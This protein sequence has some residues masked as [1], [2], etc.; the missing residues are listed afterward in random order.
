[1]N[2]INVLTEMDEVK[3]VLSYSKNIGFFFGAG[4][5]C[6]I[7]LPD[8]L[9]LT[10]EV[11]KKLADD[12]KK[13]FSNLKISL[14]KLLAKSD[15]SVEEVLNYIRQIREITGGK[16]DR[17]YDD[18]DGES[19]IKLDQEICTAIF[20]IIKEYEEKADYT[21]LRKFFAWLDLLSFNCSKEIFTTN[22][23]LLLEKAMEVNYIPYFDGFVGAYEPFFWPDSIE[24]FVLQN[25]LT[26]NWIRLWKIHGS[27]NWAWKENAITKDSK[28]VRTS[29]IDSPENELVIYPSREKYSLSRKQPFIAYFD[30]LRNYLLRA[31]VFFIMTGYS[32]LDQH[33]NEVVFNCLRQNPRLY[34]IVFCF[35]DTQVTM[36]EEYGKSYLNFCVMGPKTLI[37]NGQKSIWAF[38]DKTGTIEKSEL[39]WNKT[40][41]QFLLGNF[42]KL[43]EFLISNS[44]KSRIVEDIIRGK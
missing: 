6:S 38:D 18:I 36:L 29:K 13:Y 16:K 43:V 19:A 5:S 4:T 2:S 11:E 42:I 26:F 20:K 33:I 7:G 3:K 25:D 35:T 1:M 12:N 41:E 28:I 15:I 17:V 24:K 8:I 22:Y 10:F 21:I 31:E 39:F 44:G 30:R 40:S 14:E 34:I 9:T 32:F 23:D 37:I 27:L